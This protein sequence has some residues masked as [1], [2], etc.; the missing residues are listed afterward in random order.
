MEGSENLHSIDRRSNFHSCH[1]HDVRTEQLRS[2][3]AGGTA[4]TSEKLYNPCLSGPVSQSAS[5]RHISRLRP[6]CL[7]LNNA[8][9]MSIEFIYAN[10]CNSL[11]NNFPTFSL[12]SLFL[13]IRQCFVVSWSSLSVQFSAS[14]RRIRIFIYIKAFLRLLWVSEG[15]S[16][17]VICISVGLLFA[18]FLF[19]I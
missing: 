11:P 3:S 14:I 17:S 16:F 19:Y 7:A 6:A 4:P 2:G 18:Q 5:W 9:V 13:N 8:K 15:M 12:D 1:R 10:P